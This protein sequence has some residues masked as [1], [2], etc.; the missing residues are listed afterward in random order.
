M[1]G[2]VFLIFFVER[3]LF[4]EVFADV[5]AVFKQ[6]EEILPKVQIVIHQVE[7]FCF[8]WIL[9]VLLDEECLKLRT[10]IIRI[11]IIFF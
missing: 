1:L 10:V 6:H 5:F 2:H 8:S 3:H 11:V 7:Y 9:F 4:L